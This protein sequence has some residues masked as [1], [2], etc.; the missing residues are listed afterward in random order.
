MS[1]I[2]PYRNP[3]PYVPSSLGE[4]WDMLGSM[5]LH[6]PTFLDE[7]GNFP[8]RSIETEFHELT[9]GFAR[10]RGKLGE[11][12]Y[13]QLLDFAARAKVLFAADPEDSNGKTDEGRELLFQ[14]EDLLKEVRSRRVEARLPH[15]EGEI[16]GD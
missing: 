4:I 5:I 1:Y 11:E 3:E 8:E 14:I 9:Q 2:S 10:V 13:A 7:T 12:R 15:D 16:T 6:P